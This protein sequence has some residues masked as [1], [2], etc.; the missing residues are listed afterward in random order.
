MKIKKIVVSFALAF[1]VGI[2]SQNIFAMSLNQQ[3]IARESS[4]L[5]RDREKAEYVD[6]IEAA[7]KDSRLFNEAKY[8]VKI[9]D[10]FPEGVDETRIIAYDSVDS[11][12]KSLE[13]EEVGKRNEQETIIE[14]DENS[15]DS[16]EMQ[17]DIKS[18]KYSKYASVTKSYSRGITPKY[19]LKATFK[20]NKGTKKIVSVTGRKFTL[21]GISI[22]AGAED[23]TYSTTY[24]SDK[25]KATVKCEY[26]AISYLLTPVGRIEISRHDAYQQ[27]SYSFKNGVTGGKGGY[28]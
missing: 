9:V 6:E 28:Q 22:S 14:I 27:F 4:V 2:S 19:T 1:F 3:D 17:E 13:Q 7:I 15:M 25:K 16:L 20:Y 11:I 23:K 24:S 21:S 10:K 5:I 12:I 18:G 26:T 8:E